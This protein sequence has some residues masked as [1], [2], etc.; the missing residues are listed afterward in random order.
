MSERAYY[1]I[2]PDSATDHIT[3]RGFQA[4]M[5]F[6]APMQLVAVKRNAYAKEQKAGGLYTTNAHVMGL[7]LGRVQDAT[8]VHC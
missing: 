2:R 5:Q 1:L 7:A 6:Q 4:C 8:Q 3:I